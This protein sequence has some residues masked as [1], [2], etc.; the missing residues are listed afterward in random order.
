MSGKPA[1]NLNSLLMSITRYEVR[2][3]DWTR[4]DGTRTTWQTSTTINSDHWKREQR[5]IRKHTASESLQI[6][7]IPTTDIHNVETYLVDQAYKEK[8]KRSETIPQTNLLSEL[9]KIQAKHQEQGDTFPGLKRN[10]QRPSTRQKSELSL[11]NSVRGVS[12]PRPS[13]WRSQ[14]D[15]SS[16]SSASNFHKSTTTE[17]RPSLDRQ[18]PAS[19]TTKVAVQ[20][21]DPSCGL[22]KRTP[23]KQVISSEL[24]DE[25]K[26]RP[27][28]SLENI[29]PPKRRRLSTDACSPATQ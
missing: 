12:I 18:F 7:V 13:T 11:A 4:E 2:W 16:I 28:S 6:D 17:L 10:N 27:S 9:A 19:S 15:V 25:T 23:V 8:M 29:P 24:R 14:S 5:K 26:M 21:N 1:N 22:K 3:D 20:K